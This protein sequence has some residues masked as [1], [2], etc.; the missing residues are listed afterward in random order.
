MPLVGMDRYY[1]RDEATKDA[2][3]DLGPEIRAVRDFVKTAN[4]AVWSPTGDDSLEGFRSDSVS[5]TGF[6][7][8][9]DGKSGVPVPRSTIDSVRHILQKGWG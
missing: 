9:G 7:D 2:Y 6:D 8:T 4:R 3:V 1:W 5:H